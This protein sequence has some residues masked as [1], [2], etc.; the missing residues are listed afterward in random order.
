MHEG[1][2]DN[3]SYQ[4]ISASTPIASNRWVTGF[5][6]RQVYRA[7]EYRRTVRW[8]VLVLCGLATVGCATPQ[9]PSL[10]MPP[11]PLAPAP[12]PMSFEE[13]QQMIMH[14]LHVL[15]DKES[16]ISYLR[17]HQQSQVK[18]LKET[19]SQA[20]RAEVKLRRFA[21]EADV[22]SRLAEV[23]VAMERLQSMLGAE[24]K[25]SLQALAQKLLDTASASF[26]QDEYSIA[27]DHVEQA[28]QF[29]DMLIDNHSI[30]ATKTASKVLFKVI[31]PLKVKVDS[32]LRYQPRNSADALDVLQKNTP[33]IALAY[34][35]QWLHVQTETGKTGWVLAEL[36]AALQDEDI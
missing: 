5:V 9:A 20:A 18:E 11:P 14:L 30:S 25:V 10:V 4:V 24:R 29:I 34:H 16:E 26:K 19:T 15:A 32:H 12:L 13:Q 33:V 8:L 17:A 36:L 1:I 3:S 7:A 31:I 27:A 23:E 35:G 6:K 2:T 21:T 22:A 28:G